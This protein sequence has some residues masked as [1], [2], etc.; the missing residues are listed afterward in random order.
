MGCI[1]LWEWSRGDIY[2]KSKATLFEN[3]LLWLLKCTDKK[4]RWGYLIGDVHTQRGFSGGGPTVREKNVVFFL[5]FWVWFWA[6]SSADSANARWMG[7]GYWPKTNT[8]PV[9]KS[10]VGEKRLWG[11]VGG[12]GL[13]NL[14]YSPHLKTKYPSFSIIFP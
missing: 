2:R 3:F 7:V 4:D 9:N 8:W 6:W 11:L 13:Q 12:V 10:G 1:F 5:L 14:V